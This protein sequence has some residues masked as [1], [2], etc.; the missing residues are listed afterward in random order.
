LLLL[1]FSTCKKEITADQDSNSAISYFQGGLRDKVNKVERTPDGGFLYCGYTGSYSLSTDAFM[2]KVDANGKKMWYKTYGGKNGDDFFHAIQCSDGGFLAV[3]RTN[4]IGVS[5]KDSNFNYMDYVVKTNANGDE[6]WSKSFSTNSGVDEALYSVIEAPDHY[7]YATG[8]TW[9]TSYNLQIKKFDITGNLS[10]QKQFTDFS[11]YPPFIIQQTWNEGG[12]NISVNTN[13]D[14][15]IGGL[16]NHNIN[17]DYF[18]EFITFMMSVKPNG[19]VNFFYPYYDYIRPA[20]YVYFK[21]PTIKISSLSDGY[22]I[23]TILDLPGSKLCIQL[24]KTDLGGKIIWEKK[25]NGL[26]NALV[27]DMMVLADGSI[28]LVGSSSSETIDHSFPELFTYLKTL[29]MKLDKDGNVIFTSY[30]G[31]KD[32]ANL[33]KCIQPLPNGGWA[34]A[35]YTCLTS[36][37]YD[38]MFWMNLNSNG[39][40]NK[41]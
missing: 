2:M 10:Y 17:S 22:L 23:A 35:G 14:L 11:T 27:D 26:G 29:L 18:Y 8:L 32:N 15:I 24:L 12:L 20:N 7:F 3:G 33:A 4:S 19:V 28:L 25:Y 41:D 36:I 21:Y 39:E 34:V 40:L 6:E 5:V 31:S 13:G 37:A 30:V 9:A 1:T 38:K 16:M